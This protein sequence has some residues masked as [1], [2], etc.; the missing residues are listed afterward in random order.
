MDTE[1]IELVAYIVFSI[2]F[3]LGVRFCYNHQDAINRRI[4][5][6]IFGSEIDETSN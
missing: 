4:T 1:T 6:K 2:A 5:K 3:I